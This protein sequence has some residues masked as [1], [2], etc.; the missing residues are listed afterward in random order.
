MSNTITNKS[1][2]NLAD[3]IQLLHSAV[4][5]LTNSLNTTDDFNNWT[6]ADSLA[7]IANSLVKKNSIENKNKLTREQV[8]LIVKNL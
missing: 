1:I 2:D 5:E 4:D 7:S 6:Y 8:E 3:Q